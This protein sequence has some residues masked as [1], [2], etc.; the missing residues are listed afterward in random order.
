MLVAKW[1]ELSEKQGSQ[2]HVEFVAH[3]AEREHTAKAHGFP[4]HH[5][6]V[7]HIETH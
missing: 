3:A 2:L 4:S 7:R 1:K 5:R 6:A